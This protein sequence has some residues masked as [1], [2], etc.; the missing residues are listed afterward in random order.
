M[1]PN[2]CNNKN[3]SK[4]VNVMQKKKKIVVFNK[5]TSSSIQTFEVS[6]IFEEINTYVHQGFIKLIKG[7]SKTFDWYKIW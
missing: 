3:A 4:I 1:L 7:D 6:K 2:N 5:W